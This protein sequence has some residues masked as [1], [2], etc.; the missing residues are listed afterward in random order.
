VL[1]A[2]LDRAKPVLQATP[3]QA[4]AAT[5]GQD[6]E[7]DVATPGQ[8]AVGPESAAIPL[9]AG[10]LAALPNP[11]DGLG[12]VDGR[13]GATDAAVVPEALG[14]AVAAVQAVLDRVAPEAAAILDQAC[15]EVWVNLDRDV[16]VVRREQL[17]ASACRGHHQR[18]EVRCSTRWRC[19]LMPYWFSFMLGF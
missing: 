13:L 10:R 5:P 16:P 4:T 18:M 2:I 1:P 8:D 17:D 3:D 15:R 14:Q 19:E 9:A 12:A 6:D 11:E 7:E